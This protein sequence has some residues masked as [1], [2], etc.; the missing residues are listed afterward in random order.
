MRCLWLLSVGTT[1][2]QFPAWCQDETGAW[3][4]LMRVEVGRHPGL[5]ALHEGLLSLAATEGRVLLSNDLP[6]PVR[7]AKRLGVVVESVEVAGEQVFAARLEQAG[8]GAAA[9]PM[10]ISATGDEVPNAHDAQLVLYFPKVR[11]MVEVIRREQAGAQLSVVVLN[12]N[13]SLAGETQREPF[14]AGPLTARFVAQQLGL[15]LADGGPGL[16]L[17]LNDGTATWFDILQGGERAETPETEAAVLERLNG[18]IDA[19]A[20]GAEDCIVVSASGGLPQL[21]AVI[22]RIPATRIGAARVRLLENPEGAREPQLRPLVEKWTEREALRFQCAEALRE[23]DLAAAYGLAR[24][25]SG[26]KWAKKVLARVGPLLELPSNPLPGYPAGCALRA[27]R[28]EAALAMGDVPAAIR[29]LGV[30]L[31]AAVW[32]ILERS[33]A[34]TNALSVDASSEQLTLHPG[35]ALPHGLDWLLDPDNNAPGVFKLRTGPMFTQL[36][37]WVADREN[38]NQGL[39]GAATA[40][41]ALGNEYSRRQPAGSDSI[42]AVRNRLSHGAGPIADVAAATSRLMG[43]GVAVGQPLGQNLLQ[44]PQVRT[45]L[46]HFD[47][48]DAPPL[49]DRLR[50]LHDQALDAAARGKV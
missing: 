34:V 6:P 30:F 20:P 42:R 16:P 46:A 17:G 35:R 36:P 49:A 37:T 14:A 3:A 48:A 7:E 12:T 23:G 13:R 29:Y 10:R 43:F 28:V 50:G 22:E 21:K 18:L 41:A 32:E 15:S 38:G 11:D 2:V 33:T 27:A 26:L 39:Q 19:F 24:R 45:L 47:A 9:R 4:E 44:V 40:L 5:R 1:D 25:R 8:A 31:E